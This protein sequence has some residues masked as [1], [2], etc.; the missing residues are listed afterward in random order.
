MKDDCQ[1]LGYQEEKIV[2]LSLLHLKKNRMRKE[3]FGG[4]SYYLKQ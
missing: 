4:D 2:V 1:F 3:H